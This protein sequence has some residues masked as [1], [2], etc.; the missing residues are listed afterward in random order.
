MLLGKARAGGFGQSLR[1]SRDAVDATVRRFAC[2]G[3]RASIFLAPQMTNSGAPHVLMDVVEE[4]ASRPG[5]VRLLCPHIVPEIRERTEVCGARVERAAA[6]LGPTLLGLQLGLR[7]DHFV[8]MNTVAV[9]RNYQ[10]FILASL[11]SGRLAHAYWYIHED[12]DQLPGAAPFLLEPG[13]QSLIGPLAEQGQLTLLAP[14]RKVKAQYD[15]LFSTD[16]TRLMPYKVPVFGNDTSPR[17]ATDY[18]TVKFLLSGS[19]TDGRKGHMIAIAAFHE[20]LKS[21][22]EQRPEA[23]RP[24]SLT[25]VGMTEDFIGQQVSA[26]GSSVL[27]ERLEIVPMVPQKRALEVTRECNAVLCCSFNEALPLYVLEGMSMGHVVLRNDAAGMEEQL[28]ETVNGFRIDS[29]DVKQFAGVIEVVLN[30]RAMPDERLQAM[31]RASQEMVAGLQPQSYV[32][33]LERLR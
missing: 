12:V 11:R 14:S 28:D 6:V 25:L 27:G 17:P 2:R 20:F 4:F 22:Y 9:P 1:L 3:E 33:T 30:R 26:I 21:Y 23:Y 5:S 24:F 29:R 10:E 13:V 19:P 31:G 8:L 16:R 32:R 7:R 18:A 15:S